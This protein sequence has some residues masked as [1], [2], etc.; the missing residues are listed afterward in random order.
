MLSTECTL[1]MIGNDAGN[2]A[3]RGFDFGI[4]AYILWGLTP[5][6]MR[7]MAHIPAVEIVAFRGLLSVP[8]AGCILL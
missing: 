1:D 7:A 4:C 8:I 3:L 2:T 6:H 5:I